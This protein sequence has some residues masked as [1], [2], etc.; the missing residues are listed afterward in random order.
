VIGPFE[1]I[2][3]LFRESWKRSSGSGESDI[4]RKDF[5]DCTNGL[6]TFNG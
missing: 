4:S 6:W 1:L 3:V 2:V 5:M